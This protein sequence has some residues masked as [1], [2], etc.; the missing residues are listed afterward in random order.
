MVQ[1]LRLRA[2]SAGGRSLFPGLGTNIPQ[3]AWGS[4]EK[5]IFNSPVTVATFQVPNSHM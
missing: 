4:Q 5:K 2:S 1:W 3:S